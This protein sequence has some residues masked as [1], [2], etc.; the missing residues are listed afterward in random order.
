MSVT[1]QTT[2]ILTTMASS[3]KENSIHMDHIGNTSGSHRQHQNKIVAPLE[4]YEDN[5]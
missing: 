4:T 3:R 5:V 2:Y 1:E